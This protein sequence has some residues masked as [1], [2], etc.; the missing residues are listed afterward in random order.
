MAV[1]AAICW[2]STSNGLR[3]TDS[4]ST[5]PARQRSAT[6][7]ASSRSPRY[8]GKI[9]ATLTAPARCP[10]RPIR[11]RPE[12]TLAGDSIWITRST[13]P[14]SIPNSKVEVATTAGNRPC[15]SASSICR[16]CSRETDPWWA[17]AISSPANSFN[18]AHNRSAKRRELANTM[19]ER[20]ARISSSTF[21]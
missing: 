6:T 18:S 16:R 13:A 15:F 4:D 11:C 20:L 2:A 12:M 5:R 19:V 9:L 14:M 8:L 7:A 10:A 17:R 3:G 21:G 1:M